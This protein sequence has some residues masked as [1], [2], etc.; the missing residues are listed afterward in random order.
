VLVDIDAQAIATA[1][2]ELGLEQS[3]QLVA[4]LTRPEELRLISEALL[5]LGTGPVLTCF[6]VLEHLHSFLALLEWS[7]ELAG[8][9]AATFILSVPNDA[10][11]STRNPHHLT[12]WSEAAFEELRQLLPREHT[13][14]RQV[15]LSGSATVAWQGGQ[16]RHELAVRVGG[17]DT[18]ATHFIVA[19]GPRH[20]ELGSAALA[21]QTDVSEQRRWERWRES[22]VAVAQR[23]ARELRAAVEAQD[24]TIANQREELRRQTAEF[25]AWRTYIHE[26]ERELG[27][28]PSGGAGEQDATAVTSRETATSAPGEDPP[29]GEP[30]ADATAGAR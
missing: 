17:E 22:D 28:P 13:L 9:H 11:W 2:R 25:D 16:A 29:P 26:L 27:R 15:G 21:V 1:A 19:F 5:P 23:Q 20:R 18:V 6:E 30:G 4:D 3:R 24:I 12:V 14:L 7:N 10:F 8:E